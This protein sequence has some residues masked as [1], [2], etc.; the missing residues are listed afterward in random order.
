MLDLID[1]YLMHRPD[2]VDDARIE[3]QR[4][5]GDPSH[6]VLYFLPWNTSFAVARHAGFLPLPFL[7]AYEMPQAIVSSEPAACI[8]AVR[9]VVDDA[10]G[11]ID[12]LRIKPH[13]LLMVGLSVGS[14]PATIVADRCRARLCS[15]TSADRG[16]LMIWQSPA[17]ARVKARA[18]A[19]G[20]RL[21][22]YAQALRGH[23]P[24]ENLRGVRRGSSFLFGLRDQ[25]VPGARSRNL[26]DLA[27]STIA[28]ARCRWVDA[29]HFRTLAASARLQRE[30][31][32]E[33]T[34]LPLAS[35]WFRPWFGGGIASPER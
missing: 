4:I 35:A 25:L 30:M 27:R 12:R 34:G 26:L 8:A 22:D 14:Y 20:H 21:R 7:A 1:Q 5:D 10:L 19:K 29:G 23:H 24:I 9:N 3:F 31:L 6:R 33:M 17:A 2:P 15:V 16:D 28:G 11:L 18:I 13:R 32:A